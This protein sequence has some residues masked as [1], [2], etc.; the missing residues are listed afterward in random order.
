MFAFVILLLQ[1]ATIL[2]VVLATEILSV[3]PSVHPSVTRRYCVN[4]RRMMSS[5]L[6]H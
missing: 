5:S 6:T 2:N 3:C 4:E 1:H